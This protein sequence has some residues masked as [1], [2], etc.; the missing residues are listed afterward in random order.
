MTLHNDDEILEF[1]QNVMLLFSLNA[2]DKPDIVR[3]VADVM[4]SLIWND[5]PEWAQSHRWDIPDSA[6]EEFEFDDAEFARRFARSAVTVLKSKGKSGVPSLKQCSA[7]YLR[8][9]GH[10]VPSSSART[11]PATEMKLSKPLRVDTWF[12]LFVAA[13]YSENASE[14]SFRTWLNVQLKNEKAFR[15]SKNGPVSF[16]MDFLRALNVT[17]PE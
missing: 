4:R 7:E 16:D 3:A 14:R 9:R 5:W 17:L 15:K 10:D 2:A 6:F 13:K 8:Q 11:K 12:G 1:D